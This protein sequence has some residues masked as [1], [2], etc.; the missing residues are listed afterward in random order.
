V[1]PAHLFIG[2]HTENMK[3]M[4]HKG[5]QRKGQQIHTCKLAPEQVIE[6]KKDTRSQRKIAAYFGISKSAVGKIKRGETW[7]HL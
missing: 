1:N 4:V 6:I 5:R 7:F 2:N 3:D